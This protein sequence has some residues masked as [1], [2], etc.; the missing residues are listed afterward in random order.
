MEVDVQRNE[1]E[2]GKELKDL[3][4]GNRNLE[5]MY[6]NQA[7]DNQILWDVIEKKL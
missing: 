7:L 4:E 6:A 2:L 5:Q 3:D 1:C